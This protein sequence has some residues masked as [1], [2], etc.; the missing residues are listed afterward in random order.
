METKHTHSGCN[1]THFSLSRLVFQCTF[2][3]RHFSHSFHAFLFSFTFYF[4]LLRF[5][6][7]ASL[8]SPFAFSFDRLFLARCENFVVSFSLCCVAES[9]NA[10]WLLHEANKCKQY[11]WSKWRKFKWIDVLLEK[12][13]FLFQKKAEK[14]SIF[15]RKFFYFSFFFFLKK[16]DDWNRIW[17]P[18]RI[19][20][21]SNRMRGELIVTKSGILF[22]KLLLLLPII[23]ERRL[24]TICKLC[25]CISFATRL[26]Q[27]SICS[28]TSSAATSAFAT[29]QHKH[30]AKN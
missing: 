21:F 5:L 12:I 13:I 4:F 25:S 14:R 8:S 17:M 18:S 3:F 22:N 27:K 15:I 19:F 16:I 28:A 30:W 1:S 23:I 10:S 2:F 29:K 24:F 20:P 26:H 9:R 6:F 11:F 7:A